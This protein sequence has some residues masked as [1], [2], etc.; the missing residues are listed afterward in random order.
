DIRG[1]LWLDAL[2]AELRALD[3]AYTRLPWGLADG[4]ATGN[5]EFRRTPAREWIMDSWTIRIP[6]VE[7][8]SG[9]RGSADGRDRYQLVG[10]DEG[11]GSVRRLMTTRGIVL[12]DAGR[13]IA[14]PEPA[15][16][17]EREPAPAPAREPVRPEPVTA[18]LNG[19]VEDAA[20]G[21]PIAGAVARIA[22]QPGE[23]VSDSAGAFVIRSIDAGTHA[24][25]IVHLGYV[26]LVDSVDVP[27]GTA[28]NLRLRLTPEAIPLTPVEAEGVSEPGGRLAAVHNRVRERTKMGLGQFIRREDIERRPVS[29]LTDLLREIRGLELIRYP[30]WMYPG[31]YMVVNSRAGILRTECKVHLFVDGTRLTTANRPAQDDPPFDTVVPVNAIEIV[32]IYL[33]HAQVPPELADGR[34]PCGV[35]AVWTR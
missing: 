17:P 11:G 5:V 18:V 15:L 24:F 28:V 8:A 23:L 26:T 10:F 6:R 14:G 31:H 2:T 1:V 16:A 27:A 3:F 7:Y 4:L 29:R 33:G 35:V 22:G 21:T 12:H 13:P 25:E 32:E 30:P 19:R 20:T 34:F 9:A